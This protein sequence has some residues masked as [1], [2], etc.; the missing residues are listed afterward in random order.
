[1]NISGISDISA[2][3]IEVPSPRKYEKKTHFVLHANRNFNASEM[4]ATVT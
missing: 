4:Q 3:N 2:K 1:M